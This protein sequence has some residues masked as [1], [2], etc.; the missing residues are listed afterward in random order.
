MVNAVTTRVI[1]IDSIIQIATPLRSHKMTDSDVLDTADS[2][3]NKGLLQPPTV[4][5]RDMPDGSV[6]CMLVDGLKR[7]TSCKVLKSQNKWGQSITVIELARN[8][9]DEQILADQ[10]TANANQK[11]TLPREFV[12]SISRLLGDNGYDIPALVKQTG[13]SKD[14]L[15]NIL[16]ASALPEE[17]RNALHD[18]R[19]S[20]KNAVTLA[21]YINSVP[22]NER[23]HYVEMA[24]TLNSTE[25]RQKL[26]TDKQSRIASKKASLNGES[27]NVFVPIPRFAGKDKVTQSYE[28]I[29]R[30]VES[31]QAPSKSL[32]ARYEVLKT[33]MGMDDD[34]LAIRKAEW[35]ADM[36][37]K[38]QKAEA[39]QAD[40]IA[41]LRAKAERLGL[42]LAE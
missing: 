21:E 23:A 4:S 31:T 3:F 41:K 33:L 36:L 30:E 34:T 32:L 25:L 29:K 27:V 2:I 1:E 11:V 19:V 26:E 15:N 17:A 18:G 8:M 20:L 9:T 39:S 13:I 35:E 40:E 37:A 6:A 28:E 7:L 42:K 16:K 14:K 24:E 5:F 12:L 10:M 38:K 22:V